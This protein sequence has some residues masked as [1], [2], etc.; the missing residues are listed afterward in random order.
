MGLWCQ[1]QVSQ[2]G[3]SICIPQ[4][5]GMQLIM[6]VWDNC[7]WHQS[8]GSFRVGSQPMRGNFILQRRLL[9]ADPIP[10]M[11]IAKPSLVN[12]LRP[13]EEYIGV[14]KLTTIGSDNGLSPSRRQAILWTNAGIL[15]I[16]PIGTNFSEISSEIHIFLLRK[17]KTLRCRLRN[18]A[19]FVSDSM[20]H[21]TQNETKHNDHYTCLGLHWYNHCNE[22]TWYLYSFNTKH[23]ITLSFLIYN[24]NSTNPHLNIQYY[25]PQKRKQCDLSIQMEY[26]CFWQQ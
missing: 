7:F 23:N 9:L 19:H 13:S 4:N 1:K 26:P 15:L 21:V 20:C 14:S 16:R 5:S 18:G 6:P 12:S 25:L 2:V 17:K 3:I 11:I 22:T 24:I 10:R 8:Q